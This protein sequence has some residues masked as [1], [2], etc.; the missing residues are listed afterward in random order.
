MEPLIALSLASNVIQ[1][2]DFSAKIVSEGQKIY[3]SAEGTIAENEEAEIVA[4]DLNQLNENLRR[5]LK[6]SEH[7]Q[8]LSDDD[9]SLVVLCE[10]CEAIARELLDKLDK[11]KVSGKHRKWKSAFQ[12][13][14]NVSSN[15]DL[16]HLAS[17]LETY[18]S[19]ITL[20]TVV[21]LR[22]TLFLNIYRSAYIL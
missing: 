11:V 15:D 3:R 2:I 14:K 22:Y 9:Q 18:R 5:S 12:A 1:I 17:R 4:K 16:E 19:E 20:H 7:T 6:D 21:S 8:T 10:K 13:L